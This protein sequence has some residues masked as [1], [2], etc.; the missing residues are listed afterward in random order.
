MSMSIC[1]PF[2]GQYIGKYPPGE[3]NISRSH[4]GEKIRKGEEKKG[5]NVKGKGRKGKENEKRGS[6]RVK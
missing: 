4:L 1:V 6:K 3:G 2:R 5:K